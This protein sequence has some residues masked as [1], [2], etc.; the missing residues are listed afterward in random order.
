MDTLRL[1][2]YNV[3]YAGV[4]AAELAWAQRREAVAAVLRR[5]RPDVVALQEVWQDQL[6]DLR[7]RLP[8]FAWI[9]KRV[10]GGEHTPVG[11]RHERVAVTDWGVFAL[12]ETPGT[13]RPGW[14]ARFPR[15]VTRAGLRTAGGD[16]LTAFAVHLDHEAERARLEG[17]ALV[18]DRAA[19]TDGP[20]VVAGDLNSE[21]GEPAHRALTAGAGLRDARTVAASTDGRHRDTYVGFEPDDDPGRLDHV[22]V[23]PGIDVRRFAVDVVDGDDRPPTASDHR[24]VVADLVVRDGP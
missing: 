19:A 2:S 5:Q 12:S 16:H 1:A 9:G 13:N 23:S 3:R 10:A 11:C 15:F 8:A 21:P 17:A 24:P 22:L 14:D 6:T 7:E 20:V 18:G 4:D